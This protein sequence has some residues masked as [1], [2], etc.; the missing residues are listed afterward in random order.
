[1][2]SMA[3]S[4]AYQLR[5]RFD[6]QPRR[7]GK[8]P[9]SSRRFRLGCQKSLYQK[10]EAVQAALFRLMDMVLTD[11]ISFLLLASYLPLYPCIAPVHTN[12]R[13]PIQ[14][15]QVIHASTPCPNQ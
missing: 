4:T 14:K 10:V 12:N 13:C 3:K 11:G 15:E 7:K 9:G 5:T 8:S 2:P 1:M 6:W